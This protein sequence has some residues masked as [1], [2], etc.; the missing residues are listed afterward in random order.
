MQQFH[1]IALFNHLLNDIVQ[2]SIH[3]TSFW[4]NHI[5]LAIQC[6]TANINQNIQS[7]TSLLKSVS[8]LI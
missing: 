6:Q 5:S 2:N 4:D 7:G 3:M 8:N 1:I